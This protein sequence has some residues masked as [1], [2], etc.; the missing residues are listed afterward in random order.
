[1][2]AAAIGTA[3]GVAL[4]DGALTGIKRMFFSSESGSRWEI[5]REIVDEWGEAYAIEVELRTKFAKAGAR[6][7]GTLG[8]L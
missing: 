2:S 4:S 8:G 6:A 5:S 1:M 7:V 3:Y